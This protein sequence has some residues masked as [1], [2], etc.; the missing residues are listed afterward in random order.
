VNFIG[1]GGTITAVTTTNA[2]GVAT[3]TLNSTAV[4][5]VTVNAT[6][7]TAP[8]VTSNTVSVPFIAQPTLA[9]VKVA[10]TGT[11]P[12]GT[13]I[14]GINA[15]VIANPA[16]GLTIADTDVTASGAGVGTLL[17]PNT[18][19]VAS[20]NLAL[21]TTGGILTGEFATLQFHVAAGTFPTAAGF[22]V[23]LT[24]AGI[25]NTVGANIPGIAVSVLSVTIQ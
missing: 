22:S 3:A 24:G 21:I 6:A 13:R 19:N 5:T 15:I 1:S 4:G 8:V 7:G 12:V 9:I 20:V 10:T 14:G 18:T 17:T 16:A 23:A 11:L 25:I 2:S